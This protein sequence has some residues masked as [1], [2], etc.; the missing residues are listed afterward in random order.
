MR[1]WSGVMVAV[2]MCGGLC[3]CGSVDSR[4]ES[5]AAAAARFEASLVAERPVEG[6]AALAPGTRDELEQSAEMP[7]VR[8]LPEERLPVAGAVRTVDVY[9][10][11]ARVVAARDT[12]FLSSFPGGWKVVAAGCTPRPRQPYQCLIK[13]G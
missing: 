11:Q 1:T 3:G 2:L 7:C 8:A 4:E 13:G 5:A 6:C 9:G 10:H 12:L